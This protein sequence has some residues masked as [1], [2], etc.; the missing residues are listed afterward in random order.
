MLIKRRSS[1]AH[2]LSIWT[3]HLRTL[4]RNAN[5][6]VPGTNDTQDVFVLG[7]GLGWGD[8]LEVALSQG[9]IVTTGQDPSVGL[10]GYIQGGGHGPVASTYGLASQQV[11]Q[12]RVVTTR[13]EVLTANSVEK[14]DLFWALRGGGGGQYGVVTEY[15]IRHF[16]APDKVAM[17]VLSVAPKGDAGINASWDATTLLFSKLPDLMDAGVAG[18]ATISSGAAATSFNPDLEHATT[19]AVMTQVFWGFNMT[20]SQLSELVDPVAK[21]LRAMGSNSS[22]TISFSPSDN[23]N[24]SAFYSSISGSNT[25]GQGGVLSSRLLGRSHV[26]GNTSHDAVKGYLQR[27]LVSQNATAGTYMTVGLS[28]GRGVIDSPADR[29]GALIPAWRSAYLHLYV[30]GGSAGVSQE[31]SPSEALAE[32]GSWLEQHKETLFREWAPDMGA[33]MNEANP[34]NGQWKKDYYGD[35]YDRLVE[36]KKKYDPTESLYVLTG[37]NNGDWEYSLQDGSLCRTS[38]N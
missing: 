34:Y 30:G 24:Y 20:A 37:I 8:V 35:S 38:Y 10:G 11:L 16:P 5:W 4:E 7:S 13:G 21:D 3:H 25:A 28:G 9:R 17:G 1:G 22:L 19:G 15:I 33:Y 26:S 18:A 29:W 36:V 32:G 23:A 2:A 31:V 14:S 27:A 12:M 6:K